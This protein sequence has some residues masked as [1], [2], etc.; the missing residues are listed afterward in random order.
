MERKKKVIR[1]G[2]YFFAG[3]RSWQGDNTAFATYRVICDRDYP[4]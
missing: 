3:Q 1:P 4:T 2:F